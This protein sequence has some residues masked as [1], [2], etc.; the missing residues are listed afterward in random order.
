MTWG[1]VDSLRVLEAYL[2]VQLADQL[3]LHTLKVVLNPKMS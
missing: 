1:G 3:V 2:H